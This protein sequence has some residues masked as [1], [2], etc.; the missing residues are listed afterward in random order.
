[1]FFSSLIL[2]VDAV[3]E[4]FAGAREVVANSGAS[5]ASAGAEGQPNARYCGGSGAIDQIVCLCG[6]LAQHFLDKKH[7]DQKGTLPLQQTLL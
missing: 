5:G 2:G 1:M 7:W 6:G 4:C 3:P